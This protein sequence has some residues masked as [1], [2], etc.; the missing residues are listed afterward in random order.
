MITNT[1]TIP[2]STQV[3]VISPFNLHSNL[4]FCPQIKKFYFSPC[5]LINILDIVSVSG[6]CSCL[7]T[8]SLFMV[9]ILSC[10]FIY[11][12]FLMIYVT[13]GNAFSRLDCC[14]SKIISEWYEREVELQQGCLLH[15]TWASMNTRHKSC[16]ALLDRQ[17]QMLTPT[18]S[19]QRIHI[20]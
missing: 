7:H 17:S 4:V 2:S 16:R 1:I 8:C 19:L 9:S 14:D 18:P 12:H 11:F 6:S 3:L 15:V 10:R 13:T 20:N 5:I